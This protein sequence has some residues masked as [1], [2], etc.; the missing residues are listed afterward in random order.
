M[1]LYDQGKVQDFCEPGTADSQNRDRGSGR[2]GCADAA[3]GRRN[4]R[5]GARP[6]HVSYKRSK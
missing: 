4:L 6:A 1:K 3:A 5:A 2:A